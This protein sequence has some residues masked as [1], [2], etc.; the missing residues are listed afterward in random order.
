MDIIETIQTTKIIILKIEVNRKLCMYVCFKILVFKGMAPV[1][2]EDSVPTT[3]R[4]NLSARQ[5]R[6]S[7]YLL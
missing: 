5:K 2:G 7:T 3:E 1:G 6:C 4:G